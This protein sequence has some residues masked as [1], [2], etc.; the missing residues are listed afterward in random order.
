[1]IKL[2]NK[3]TKDVQNLLDKYQIPWSISQLGARAEYRFTKPAPKN[4]G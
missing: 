3:F 4:G 2:C 1:M